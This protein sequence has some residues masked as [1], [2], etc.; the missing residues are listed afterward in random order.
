MCATTLR[1]APPRIS[2]IVLGTLW[3]T[4]TLCTTRPASALPP[5]K[6]PAAA[7]P[8]LSLEEVAIMV[9]SSD[10]D[11]VR[12]ALEA[13]ALLPAAE[14]L[15]IVDERIRNGLPRELLDVAIDSLL[16]LND[17]SSAPLLGELARH[18]RPEVRARSLDALARLKA[19]EAK[20]VIVTALGDPAPEVRAAAAAALGEL[21]SSENLGALQKALER[22]VDG[23]ADAL[24]RVARPEQLDR[25]FALVGAVPLARLAPMFAALLERRDV[26]ERDKL[27]AVDKLEKTSDDESRALSAKLLAELP[28]EASPRVRK[29]LA[30]AAQ[31]SAAP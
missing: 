8:T 10:D 31:A 25:L 3:C 27:R 29:A 23:A 17:R 7:R 24:G 26:S 15:P 13:A 2:S 4:L 30:Q 22:E 16:L 19:P 18:R 21:G 5:K 1:A 20:D 28:R 9:A 11:E 6:A 12:S 14:V